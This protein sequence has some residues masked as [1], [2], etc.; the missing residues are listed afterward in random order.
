M[1]PQGQGLSAEGKHFWWYKKLPNV[2]VAEKCKSGMCVVGRGERLVKGFV[3]LF[4]W[5]FSIEPVSML[6]TCH[7]LSL[8]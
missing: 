1:V 5:R 4:T 3:H 8:L 2:S 7:R 6:N